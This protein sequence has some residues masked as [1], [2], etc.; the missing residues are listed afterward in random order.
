[1]KSNHKLQLPPIVK[2]VDVSCSPDRAFAT[3]TRDI[4]LWWPLAS[5]SLAGDSF[6]KCHIEPRVGGRVFERAKDG[7]EFLWGTVLEWTP[8]LSIRF[9]WRVGHA[10]S[11]QQEVEV[12]FESVPQG[13][14]V[15][16]THSGWETPDRRADYDKGW[17]YVLG[18]YSSGLAT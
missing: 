17:N 12:R 14:R 3:F 11:S 9:T 4:H 8:P 1:M 13:T 7:Q 6:D 15:T 2:T 10:A 16:L 18:R 5:H